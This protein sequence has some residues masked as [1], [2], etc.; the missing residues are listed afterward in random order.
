MKRI[1]LAV[2]LLALSAGAFAQSATPTTSDAVCAPGEQVFGYVRPVSAVDVCKNQLPVTIPGEQVQG[3]VRPDSI[4]GLS[5]A[6][7]LRAPG[8]QVSGYVQPGFGKVSG[9]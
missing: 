1:I 6:I 9:K 2:A 7:V 3:F 4:K 8:E 5:T